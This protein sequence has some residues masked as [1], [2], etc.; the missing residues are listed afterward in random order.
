MAIPSEYVLLFRWWRSGE[1][2]NRALIWREHALKEPTLRHPSS[3]GYR[4][5][6]PVV[7]T[8]RWSVK[9]SETGSRPLS[10]F[11]TSFVNLGL[12]WRWPLDKIQYSNLKQLLFCIT[13]SLMLVASLLGIISL[14][15]I[16]CLI[17]KRQYAAQPYFERSLSW[18]LFFQFL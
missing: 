16:Q 1:S 8:K 17:D 10:S 11:S 7:K 18:F 9:S 2:S 5:P 13:D 6:A 3:N 12:L 14:F 4:R 15:N